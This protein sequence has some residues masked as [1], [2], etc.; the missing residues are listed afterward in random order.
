MKPNLERLQ[1]EEEDAL[2]EGDEADEKTS[3]IGQPTS[4]A[5]SL[6]YG[7]IRSRAPTLEIDE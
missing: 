7:V 6:M 5:E 3:L 4:R 2:K 1:A